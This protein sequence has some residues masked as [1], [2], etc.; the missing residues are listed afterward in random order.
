M[1]AEIREWMIILRNSDRVEA[2]DL[3]TEIV[4]MSL[5]TKY[6]GIGNMDEYWCQLN[7]MRYNYIQNLKKS[8]VNCTYLFYLIYDFKDFQY[9]SE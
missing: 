6:T 3:L 4:F 7:H 5:R 8:I 9:F 1:E 2:V